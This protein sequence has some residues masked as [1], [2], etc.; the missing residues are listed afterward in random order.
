MSYACKRVRRYHW[1]LLRIQFDKSIVE[2]FDAL[3]KDQELWKDMKAML[4][5]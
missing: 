1:I 4:Q 3:N 2:V 5:K